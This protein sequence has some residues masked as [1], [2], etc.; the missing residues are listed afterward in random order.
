MERDTNEIFK[1]TP[2]SSASAWANSRIQLSS[3]AKAV[4]A[5][6]VLLASVCIPE[7]VFTGN[8]VNLTC[9]WYQGR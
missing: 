8:N 6:R 4:V 7:L 1:R 5:A 9:C 2:D 3:S